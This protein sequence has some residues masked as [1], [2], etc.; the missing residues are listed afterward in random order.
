VRDNREGDS[1]MDSGGD[2][3]DH[4]IIEEGLYGERMYKIYF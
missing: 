2:L 3:K 4:S 1:I